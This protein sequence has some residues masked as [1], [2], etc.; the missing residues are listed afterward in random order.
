MISDKQLAANRANALLSQGPITEA[1]KKR[2]S[3]NA[4]RHGLMR[5]RSPR[6]PMR[7]A[8]L[9][10]LSPSLMHDLA[11]D[12]AMEIQL[13]QRIATDSWR[14]NRISAIKDNLFALGLHENSGRLCPYNE[15]V[16]AASP[17]RASSP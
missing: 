9:T 5:P 2:S 14:L 11:P 3:M 4:R 7:I 16:D 12:G 15:Q 6:C 10:T 8:P 13:A 1:G 17:L